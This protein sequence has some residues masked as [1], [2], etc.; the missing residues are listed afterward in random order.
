MTTEMKAAKLQEILKRAAKR[1]N[2]DADEAHKEQQVKDRLNKV[3]EGAEDG[4]EEKD[5]LEK[6]QRTYEKYL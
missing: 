4:E 3:R 5:L 6:I 1:Q 2:Q